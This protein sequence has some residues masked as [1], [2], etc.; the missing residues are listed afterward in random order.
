MTSTFVA[1]D[2]VMLVAGTRSQHQAHEASCVNTRPVRGGVPL[3]SFTHADRL[4]DARALRAGKMY[5]L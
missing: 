1:L 3:N 5:A 4:P 2:D